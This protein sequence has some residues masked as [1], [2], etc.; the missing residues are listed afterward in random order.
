MFLKFPFEFSLPVQQAALIVNTVLLICAL[1]VVELVYSETPKEQR[2]H[3]RYF[4]PLFLV[5]IGLLLLAV[6]KQIGKS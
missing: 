3:L 4:L 1:V 5:L 6:Y 2:T